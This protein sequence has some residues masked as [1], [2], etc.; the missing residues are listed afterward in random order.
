MMTPNINEFIVFS[1]LKTVA[2]KNILNDIFN[3][4]K[5]L[6]IGNAL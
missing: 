4:Q 1:S 6:I 3:F 2:M 5:H